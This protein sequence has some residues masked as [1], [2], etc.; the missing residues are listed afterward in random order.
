M[1]KAL[2]LGNGNILVGIDHAG[3]VRDF[4]FPYVGLENHIGG[5]N[6]HRIGVYVDGTLAWL[7]DSSWDVQVESV[8]ESLSGRIH[9]ENRSLGVSLLISDTVYNERNIFLRRIVIK[10]LRGTTRSI[11]LYFAQQFELSESSRAHTAYYDPGTHS[12]IHYR[13]KRVFLVNARLDG[14]AFDDYS[15]GVFHAEGKEG[16]HRDAEDGVLSKNPIE[17]GSADSVIGLSADYAAGEERIASYWVCVA[18]SHRYAKRL[19]ALVLHK[20]PAHMEKTTTDF[21]KAWINRQNFSFYG[22][23]P[24]AISLFK[25]SLFII[26]AHADRGGALIASSDAD[27][28][29]QGGKDNYCYMWHRDG[30]YS[31]LALDR[32]GDFT[33]SQRFFEFSNA[34]VSEHGYFMHKYSPDRSLGSSWHGWVNRDTRMPELPIQEDETAIV[35]CALERH[36]ELTKDLEFIEMVYNSL[37][38]HTAEF[39][40]SYRDEHTGL[41]L[42]SHDLWEERYGI[43]TYT[44]ASVYGALMSAS[45]FAA[46]L[47]KAKSETR[48]AEAAQEI[49]TGI[50]THLWDEER[51]YFH[52]S[53]SLVEGT[54]VPDRTLDASSA[55]GIFSFGVL[56]H[57]DT[58]LS[59]AF[60]ATE[61]ELSLSS[62]IGGIARY[63]GDHYYRVGADTPGNPWVVTTL[64]LAEYYIARAQNEADL[65]RAKELFEWTVARADKSGILPEQINP[66]SGLGLSAAPLVWSHAAYVN[67][68]ISYLDRLEA[69]GLC[70]ACNPL[71]THL[72]VAALS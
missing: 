51:G 39:M 10:N 54:L 55:Y 13:G 63:Q 64:W 11:K 33:V 41:P 52:R 16:T 71:V 7:S 23:S 62:T 70:A 8:D 25:K 45:R 49:K 14:V 21:W 40:L 31:A 34:V 69:L 28:M 24:A 5:N 19:N 30:A 60:E 9:A 68:V 56:P 43:H 15:T 53:T 27:M 46:I 58:R 50:L 32:A 36:Y 44:A 35:L 66:Y 61:R 47:G 12:I 38:K 42:A 48:F 3:Q 6:V 18:R 59:R 37:I 57:S 22:L 4:Y 20:S 1:P 65:N 26:R 72:S 67:A 17:H 2:T 29:Q